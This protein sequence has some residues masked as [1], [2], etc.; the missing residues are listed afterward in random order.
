LAYL[1]A[2]RLQSW[3]ARVAVWAGRGDADR[4]GRNSRAYLGVHCTTDVIGG[5]AFGVVWL[6]I[7]VTGWTIVTRHRRSQPGILGP[8]AEEIVIWAHRGEAKTSWKPVAAPGLSGG[9]RAGRRD[10]STA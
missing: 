7:V 3:S 4:A 9:R 8:A 1:R 10:G 5:W 6:T 2:A